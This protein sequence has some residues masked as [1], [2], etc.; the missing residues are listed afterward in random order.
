MKSC[1]FIWL[2]LR[3]LTS[4]PDSIRVLTRQIEFSRAKDSWIRV[5]C[6]SQC[7][8]VFRMPNSIIKS[9]CMIA[10][11]DLFEVHERETDNHFRSIEKQRQTIPFHFWAQM[12]KGQQN[13]Q[14]RHTVGER[15]RESRGSIVVRKLI[16]FINMIY[17]PHMISSWERPS[18]IIIVVMREI[19]PFCKFL[20]C[21]S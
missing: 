21:F 10:G 6:V 12:E 18:F 15:E 20:G 3:F 17:N 2:Y 14:S 8:C 11:T 13:I 4:L 19:A 16:N 7:V 9:D 1:V 5:V